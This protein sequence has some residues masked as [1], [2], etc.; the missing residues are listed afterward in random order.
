V[1]IVIAESAG[2]CMGVRRA[3]NMVLELMEQNQEP[4]CSIGS[5]I[6]NPQ[7]VELLRLRG[8]TPVK[9]LDE[10]DR[11]RVIIRSH[12]ISPQARQKLE[13]KG[14]E[15]LDAT[16]PRVARVHR[17][18][19]K[20]SGL[21]FLIV[22]LGDPGHSEVEGILGFA[23]GHARVVQ[24]L[25]DVKSLP[26]ADQVALVAQTTQSSAR[27]DEVA[28]ALRQRYPALGEDR[29][30]IINTIC[31]STER[32]QDEVR[33]LAKRV[34]A[35]VIVGGKESA[36]TKRLKEIAEGEGK[37]A[38]LVES[39]SELDYKRLQNFSAIG[40]TAGASTPNWMIRRVYEEL[41][42]ASL[43]RRRQF[44]VR[45]F[46]RLFRLVAI[47][48]L[49]LA[50]GGA[51]LAGLAAEL[52]TGSINPFKC[53]MAFFYLASI[54]NFTVLSSPNLLGIIEPA[55]GRLFLARRKSLLIL[56][57]FGL[58]LG[59]V[60][61]GMINLWALVFYIALCTL[62]LL[63][64]AP[65]RSSGKQALIPVRSL[66]DIPGSKDIFSA[67]AW[68]VVIVLVPV[69]GQYGAHSRAEVWLCFVLVFLMVFS[70]SLLQDFRDLQADRMVG[71]E[72]LPI[73]LGEK[74]SRALVYSIMALAGAVLAVSFWQGLIHLPALGIAAGLVWLWL[75]VPLFTRKTL[76][77]GLRAELLID[78]SFILAGAIGLVLGGF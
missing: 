54:H 63:Y 42:Q 71:K 65:F 26:D 21:G 58:T 8:V 33:Q 44:P 3:V 32:R 11:G 34:D 22:V 67:L 19:E 23:N 62:S 76:I 25:E 9:S 15:V 78:F 37:P 53:L 59:G 51:L 64:Q 50:L 35:F 74:R 77:Q 38:F 1:K 49:Y 18:V 69:T 2:F 12:G 55:R 75:C 13:Q 68:S 70:R 52:L 43:T 61:A 39:E 5:L 16:C 66:M 47:F 14:L 6:H 57:L 36:N 48:N 24:S 40:L 28:E 10:V 56:S 72:T 31:D 27:F 17:A 29:L 73:L 7:V 41:R 45:I 30:L 46:Y 60:C 20:Y 4:V